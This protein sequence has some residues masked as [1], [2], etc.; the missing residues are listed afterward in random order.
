MWSLAR[1]TR[2]WM[3]TRERAPSNG[4]RAGFGAAMADL[5]PPL[6]DLIDALARQVAADYLRDEALRSNDSDQLRP[7]PVPLHDIDQAA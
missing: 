3:S 6:L 4:S 1:R 5:T 7:T 2:H